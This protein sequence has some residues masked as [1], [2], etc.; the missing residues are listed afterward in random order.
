M[1]RRWYEL[2]PDVCIVMSK[3]EL[4]KEE[5]RTRYAKVMLS[6][7]EKA[8]YRPNEQ[9]YSDRIENYVMRRWYDQNQFLF[10]AFEYLKDLNNDVQKTVCDNVLNFMK[11]E[12]AA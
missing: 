4:A 10:R 9:V 6:E 8:G 3:I 2:S 7:L 5:D 12:N 11:S 1:K